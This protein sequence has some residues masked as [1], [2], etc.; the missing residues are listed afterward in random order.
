MPSA[1]QEIKQVGIRLDGIIESTGTA[2]GS[3]TLANGEQVVFTITTSS[4]TGAKVFVVADV[5]LYVGSVAVANQL[6]GGSSIDE[7]QWQIIGPWSD[8]GA[9]NNVNHKTLVYVRNI[10]AGSLTV[11]IRTISRA[12]SNSRTQDTSGT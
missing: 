7:S 11:L 1:N 8:W 6:P 10:S 3:T 5:S 9:T 12:I 2:S 4:D